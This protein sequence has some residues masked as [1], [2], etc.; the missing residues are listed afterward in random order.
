MRKFDVSEISVENYLSA[1][2]PFSLH[3]NSLPADNIIV[4]PNARRFI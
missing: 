1:F 2:P 4:K 3:K